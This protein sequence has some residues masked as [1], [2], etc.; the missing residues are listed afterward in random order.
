M[1]KWPSQKHFTTNNQSLVV[2]SAAA[3]ALTTMSW[4]FR[5][6]I[7]FNFKEAS[8]ETRPHD[9]TTLIPFSLNPCWK[10][11]VMTMHPP[12]C[13]LLQLTNFFIPNPIFMFLCNNPKQRRKCLNSN[14]HDK[15]NAQI[16]I[17]QPFIFPL[18]DCFSIVQL[19]KKQT[20]F[21]DKFSFSSNL[22]PRSMKMGFQHQW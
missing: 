13:L 10:K 12:T 15:S 21:F 11:K 8:K 6:C 9:S 22:A 5:H 1:N 3:I 17:C 16:K 4:I 20:I 2:T 19:Q 14:K 7:H 18:S